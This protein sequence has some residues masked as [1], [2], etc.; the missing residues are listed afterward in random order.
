LINKSSTC[1]GDRLVGLM[2][3][4]AC[5]CTCTHMVTYYHR[6]ECCYP[7]LHVPF[8]DFGLVVKYHLARECWF[9]SCVPC[10]DRGRSFVIRTTELQVKIPVWVP[11][12]RFRISSKETTQDYDSEL[13]SILFRS[14][15]VQA[16]HNRLVRA[17]VSCPQFFY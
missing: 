5:T 3:R 6:W 12:Y 15:L 17:C 4:N 10:N 7:A 8:S 14:A 2:R 9:D 1:G 16:T 13:E 11:K